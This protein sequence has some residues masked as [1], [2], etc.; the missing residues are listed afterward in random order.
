MKRAY[1]IA[2][3]TV[4]SLGAVLAITP[5]QLSSSETSLGTGIGV[6]PV[7]STTI[8]AAT[9]TN[10]PTPAATKSA[11]P[12]K[13]ATATATKKATATAKATASATATAKATTS[14]A[15]S[16]TATASPT[17]TPV[18]TT[19]SVSGSFT[20][21]LSSVGP[22]G[23]VVV[24]ITVAS[25]KITDVQAVQAPGGQNQRYTD[26]AVPVM[27]QRALA[28]QSANITGVSGA[29]YTSYNFWKSLTSAIA[30]AGL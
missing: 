15:P 22:Y 1:L 20:G 3:G 6:T 16:A 9:Q 4:G 27:R 24:K 21:D 10:N 2:G 11:A 5:P 14:A 25:G 8:A 18:A 13:S 7:A 28:A 23:G 29:S 12:A 30:K 17:P 19:K 26:R